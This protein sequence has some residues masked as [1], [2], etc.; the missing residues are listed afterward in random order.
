MHR[1]IAFKLLPVGE[2]KLF[3]I[4]A[5][6]LDVS[7]IKGLAAGPAVVVTRKATILADLATGIVDAA[8]ILAI[9]DGEWANAIM[10]VTEDE[11]VEDVTSAQSKTVNNDNAFLQSVHEIAPSIVGLAQTTVGLV[12]AAGVEGQLVK[13]TKGRWV[14][15]PV[16]SFTLKVQ[17]R[18]KN[19]QFTLYG[20]PSSYQHGGFLRQDQNSYSRG[21]VNNEAEAKTLAGLVA[22]AHSRKTK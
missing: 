6:P 8:D 5:V 18:K 12:R 22:Q 15:S 13:M 19:L 9:S 14:N 10:I 3:R 1:P 20:N 7:S 17:P 2:V 4:G 21:W 11:S 16:N